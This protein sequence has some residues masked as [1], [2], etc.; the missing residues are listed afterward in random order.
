MTSTTR[1][2][3]FCLTATLSLPVDAQ[4][5]LPVS[6]HWQI[7]VGAQYA[8]GRNT[9][10]YD[11]RPLNT[12]SC[13]GNLEYVLTLPKLI[14]TIFMHVGYQ[15]LR[16]QGKSFVTA[17]FWNMEE[18]ISVDNIRGGPGLELRLNSKGKLHPLLGA[19]AY[20]GRAVNSKY[21]YQSIEGNT[22]YDLPID[23]SIKGGAGL[24]T[25][26]QVFA[27][28]EKVFTEKIQ[29]RIKAA[30]GGHYQFASWELPFPL[31]PDGGA[32]LIK[33]GYWQASLEA[34]HRL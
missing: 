5:V 10:L 24:Y 12:F 8:E 1:L 18:T 26:G 4:S 9:N 23:L 27:G 19:Q 22:P 3:I 17:P 29:L 30:L 28:L 33:G 6:D 34:V 15:E 14:V 20:W 21:Q 32:Q 2:I 13:G 11:A 16:V 31:Q 25:G 7:S